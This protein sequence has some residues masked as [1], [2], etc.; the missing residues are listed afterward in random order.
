M[1][2][3]IAGTCLRIASLLKGLGVDKRKQKEKIKKA[4]SKAFHNTEKY[5]AY[6]NSGNPPD[7]QREID[8]A[9]DWEKAGIL[10]E[11]VDRNLAQRIAL[12]TNFWRDGGTWNDDQIKEAGIQ[13]KRIRAEGMTLFE[14]KTKP[15]K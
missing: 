3:T 2:E 4:V 11:P 10:I 14:K 9:A 13:L 7:R 12:K 6:R 15:K 5:Y 1:W 8:L